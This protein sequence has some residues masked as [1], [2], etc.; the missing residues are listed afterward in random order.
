MSHVKWSA[1]QQAQRQRFKQAV[2]YARAAMADERIRAHYEQQAAAQ[3]KRRFDL[4]V[5]DYFKG[6]NLIEELAS[7][8]APP[9]NP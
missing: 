8:S 6:R 4:A 5:S 2:A 7:T 9:Q 3:G 1:A